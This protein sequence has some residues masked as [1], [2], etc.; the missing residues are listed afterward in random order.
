MSSTPVSLFVRGK[1]KIYARETK[2]RFTVWRRAAILLTQ[3][4][5]YGLPWLRWNGR[6]A[7]WFDLPARKFHLFGLLLW[8]QDIVYLA[9]L[10]ILGACLVFFLSALAGRVWCGFGCPHTVYSDIFRW[11]ERKAEGSR[12]ARMRLDREPMSTSKLMRKLAKHTGWIAVA[13][14]TGMTLA[15]YF[16]PMPVLLREAASFALGPWQMFCIAAYAGL[17]YL[18]A[19]WMREQFCTYI[20]AWARFQSVMLD[21]DTLVVAYDR[22]RGEPRGLRNRKRDLSAPLGDCMDC[23]ICVQVCPAGIDIRKGFQYQCI[24]CAA[25][26]DACDAVM[27]KVGAPRGL[28]RYVAENALSNKQSPGQARYRLLR[29]RLLAYIAVLASGMLFC[30]AML[31]TRTPLRLDVVM[32]RA[33][34]GREAGSGM[35]ENVY[36]LQVMNAEERPHRYRLAVSGMESIALVSETE[37]DVEGATSRTVPV[38]VRVAQ[39]KAVPGANHIRFELVAHDD[40]TLRATEPAVFFS[41]ESRPVP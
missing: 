2:G 28:I 20:C 12:S 7:I 34:M 36:R 8:P 24:D 25:C 30:A 33:T 38:S 3:L 11:I 15:A 39:A 5:F 31:I 14:W 35:I 13:L 6:P 27:D 1:K 4:V 29:P 26:I 21:A 23:T 17:C 10:L 41:P 32:D 18:N 16:T 19:G 40:E 22:A 37:I 9:G